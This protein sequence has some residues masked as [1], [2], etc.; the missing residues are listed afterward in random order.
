MSTHA[1]RSGSGGRPWYTQFWPWVLIALPAV[2]V[3]VSV[4]ALV[5]A[6][7]HADPVVGDD[8]YARGLAI[9]DDLDRTAAAAARGV[10][11]TVEV[12]AADAE[13]V[14]TLAGDVG[15]VDALAVE[16]QHPTIAAR[17][18]AYEL[19]PHGDGSFRAPLGSV[20]AGRWYVTLAPASGDWRLAA[21]ATFVAGVPVRLAP[22]T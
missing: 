2:S 3:A 20:P 16:L 18:R 12:D 5:L 17:D 15:A 22:A 11:A 1:T 10:A 6:I 14:V 7:R 4:L 9:N 8:W 19:R 21:Q 13:L